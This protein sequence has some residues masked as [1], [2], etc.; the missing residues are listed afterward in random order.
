MKRNYL[1][2]GIAAIILIG[3]AAFYFLF[4]RAGQVEVG[5]PTRG[6]AVEAVYATGTVEPVQFARVGTKV[7]G[8][9]ARILVHEGDTVAKGDL[10]AQLDAEAEEA[11]VRELEARLELAKA[12]AA[13]TRRLYRDGNVSKAALDKATSALDSAR[14]SLDAARARLEDRQIKAPLDGRVLRS[15]RQLEIGDSVQAGQI[16]FYIG[17]AQVLWIEAEVDEEDIPQVSVGQKAFIRSDAFPGQALS[18]EVAEITPFG[19][20]V[21]RSYRV[22][23]S[24]PS[25]SPLLAGMTVEVNIVIREET[26]ALLVPTGA[27]AGQAV[28]VVENKRAVRRP[29]TLGAIGPDQAEVRAGIS[30]SDEIILNPSPTLQ[31]GTR[32][33]PD[34]VNGQGS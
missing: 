3:G 33:R 31:E 30:E 6:P 14:A 2:A 16:L 23:I 4:F 10:L 7:S 34:A 19:D 1:L 24:L 17:N 8:R 29:V 18:G 5:T 22:H 9:V 11:Q 21:A 13:R 20:P 15:E 26:D 12:D 27:L 25:D 32:V 28:W